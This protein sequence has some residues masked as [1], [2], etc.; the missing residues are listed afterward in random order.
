MIDWPNLFWN[1]LWILACALGLTVLS[2]TGWEA[3]RRK[4][5]F[6]RL[7]SARRPQALLNLAGL[8]FCAGL[9]GASSAY[10]EKAVWAL[11]GLAFIVQSLL[12]VR[13]SGR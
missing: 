6:R 2:A 9:A 5:A 3:S 11:L 1:S 7:L 8:L 4:T 12:V 10:W 13:H